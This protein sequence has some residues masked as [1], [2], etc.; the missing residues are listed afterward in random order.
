[1]AEQQIAVFVAQ[2]H[3]VASAIAEKF[4][5]GAITLAHPFAVAIR[6]EA[7]GPYFPE[8]VAV[9]VA[10]LIV[11]ADARTCRNRAI[12][13][14]RSD[15]HAGTACVEMVADIA[16]VIAEKTLAAVTCLD[17]PL[18]AGAFDKLHHAAKLLAGELQ[19]VVLCRTS[20]GKYG[21]YA[22]RPD[23]QSD[24][25]LFQFVELRIVVA[26]GA[27]YDI[28]HEI[29]FG[30]H[31]PYGID[32]AGE[33]L[34]IAAHTVVFRLQSVQTYRR[35]VHSCIAQCTKPFRRHIKT[36]GYHT[37][38][39]TLFI[40]CAT[41]LL[42]IVAHERFA[43]RNDYEHA[44]GVGMCRHVVEYS[45]EILLRHIGETGRLLAVAAAM[46]A[47]QIASQRTLPE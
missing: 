30:S 10:L 34:R 16:L 20:N 45:Q 18:A 42:Q 44:V 27:R 22:P 36:V 28:E 14:H 21:E 7:V 2:M 38:R 39:K 15:R 46:A 24:K 31:R 41:A 17:A 29:G 8:I 1:M 47:M 11:G 4:A 26:V 19:I 25:H 33:T 43:A 5:L 32:S 35:R 37:P 9:Y 23:T 3:A 12:D 6:G 40:D 13:K